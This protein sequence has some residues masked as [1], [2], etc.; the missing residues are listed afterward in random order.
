MHPGWSGGGDI[1]QTEFSVG[2][3]EGVGTTV[4]LAMGNRDPCHFYACPSSR[5]GLL[6]PKRASLHLCLIPKLLPTCN[7]CPI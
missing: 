4:H 7:P 3:R 6:C 1:L 5:R 2:F